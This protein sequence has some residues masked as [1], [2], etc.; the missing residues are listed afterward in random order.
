M[1]EVTAKLPADC[2]VLAARSQANQ[3]NIDNKLSYEDSFS[4]GWG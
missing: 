3:S 1:A 2:V 4:L